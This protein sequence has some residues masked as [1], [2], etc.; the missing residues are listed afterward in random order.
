VKRL[1]FIV[2]LLLPA[3]SSA[4]VI[5]WQDY[6]DRTFVYQISNK[7]SK[8][9]IKSKPED[10]LV[11]K[12]LHTPVAAF[13]GE[14]MEQPKQG[15]FIFA[16]I[17]RNKVGYRYVPVMPFQVFL[18]KQYGVLSLQVIDDKGNIRDNAKVRIR[19]GL[20]DRK[21]Y[22]DKISRTYSVDEDSKKT[23]RLL[24]VE[25]DGFE[26]IF[27]L[28]KHIVNP[29]WYS[30]NRYDN[31]PDFYSYMITD[32][33]KYKPGE[34][35]R[36]KSY[37]LSSRKRPLKKELEIWLQ[38]EQYS[39]H[40]KKIATILPYHAGGYA[41]EIVLH[42][43]LKLRIDNNY[44]IQL[45]EKSGRIV[46]NTSFRYE[47]YELYDS[48]IETK[49]SSSEHYFPDTNTVEIKAIDANGLLLQD[50]KAEIL[51][52]RNVVLNSYTPLLV[53]SD[54]LMFRNIDLDNDKPSTVD[55]PP[56]IF[57]QSDCRY[58]LVVTVRSYDNQVLSSRNSAVFFKSRQDISCSTHN[59]SICFEYYVQGKK[60]AAK[61][62]IW[63]NDSAVRK[64]V[65]MPYSE[66][67]NQ[68]T[69][70]YTVRIPESS[71]SKTIETKQINPQLNIEGGIILDSFNVKLLNPLKLELSWYIYQGNILIEKGSGKEFDFKYPDTNLD[72]VHYVEI[73]YF[74]GEK[75]HAYRRTFVPKV[76]FL[77]VNIDLPE[78]I[79][80][81]QTLE[82]NISVKDNMGNPVGNVDLTAFA[83]NSQLNYY[84]PD[85]PSYSAEPQSREQRSSYS[86]DKKHYSFNSPL[87]YSKWHK[88]AQLDTMKYYQFTYPWNKMFVH[89]ID[90]PDST[91]QFAPYV[92]KN[93][94]AI[95]IYVIEQNS[96]PVYFLWTNNPKQYSFTV[97]DAKLRKIT[98]RLH[99]RALIL[100]SMSFEKGKK[101]I[102]SIDIDHLPANVKTIKLDTRDKYKRYHFTDKE[103]FTYK[104]YISQIPVI[105]TCDFTY[106]KDENTI[107]PVYHFCFGKSASKFWQDLFRRGTCNMSMA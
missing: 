49:L 94:E 35:V 23:N 15:H 17:N 29:T 79:Y 30:S 25:L 90:T 65:N 46:A 71:Y 59:D 45:R 93:G 14:W 7:E 37:S 8:R 39:M 88:I 43:S 48:R 81:G 52:K 56:E 11:L 44:N 82:A 24:T 55:I 68:A 98:L 69:K 80:P 41:D 106:L 85:L 21:V 42:D 28:A 50:V 19:G 105:N 4:Q 107:Y 27:D 92:M 12:M 18:F 61:A 67:F 60:V 1:V 73:F 10:S 100:D 34:K 53:L 102:F 57:N 104:D 16:N 99:D 76:D 101:T 33:N 32:K 9:L 5:R 83:N 75:E 51:V 22:F 103:S 74:M 96:T 84:V 77:D 63:Y 38:T 89:K 64:T 2:L 31:R 40:Y 62:E 70:R 36:F 3:C 20:F 78:R 97:P 66:P 72:A 87:D 95:N 54:T 58:E 13:T 6:C 86:V 91:A 47:D 26:A